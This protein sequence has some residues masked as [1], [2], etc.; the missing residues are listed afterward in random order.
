MSRAQRQLVSVVVMVAAVAI[1]A[2]L[3]LWLLG[4]VL[5]LIGA[6]GS[7]LLY[8]RRR[9][10]E[11]ASAMAKNDL[12]TVR[13]MVTDPFLGLPARLAL[14]YARMDVPDLAA[15]TCGMCQPSDNLVD[16]FAASIDDEV[17]IHQRLAQAFWTTS[18][19]PDAW[20]KLSPPTTPDWSLPVRQCATLGVILSRA[21]DTDDIGTHHLALALLTKVEGPFPLALT[22]P[23]RLAAARFAV[24][25]GIYGAAEGWLATIP[26]FPTES[27]LEPIRRQCLDD[28]G[29]HRAESPEGQ[30]H[31]EAEREVVDA[32]TADDRDKLL[33]IARDPAHHGALASR[34]YLAG[35]AIRV[36]EPLPP[37]CPCAT[38]DAG[39]DAAALE[40]LL[41]MSSRVFGSLPYGQDLKNE[42][43]ALSPRKVSRHARLAYKATVQTLT[44]AVQALHTCTE[45]DCQAGASVAQILES[46]PDGIPRSVLALA[47]AT[48]TARVGDAEGAMA[49]LRSLHPFPSGTALEDRRLELVARLDRS[50]EERVGPENAEACEAAAR[51]DGSDA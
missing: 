11:L 8:L 33:A 20:H 16:T 17:H 29:A 45:E 30:A 4:V 18:R 41:A 47:V 51:S 48:R 32:M 28:L 46:L 9:N 35:Q 10:A 44:L 34:F 24:A 23:T 19:A 31:I 12:D 39:D 22:W 27:P 43:T 40:D 37:S 38:C 6:A 36:A 5:F 25:R 14:A 26:P 2:K 1:S 3:S 15:C 42:V 7:L 49:L 21:L 50:G 13:G